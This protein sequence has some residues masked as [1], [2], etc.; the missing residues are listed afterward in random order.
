[1]LDSDT[2]LAPPQQER[3][4]LPSP[5]QSADKPLE[6]RSAEGR[7]ERA[8]RRPRRLGLIGAVVALGAVA[9]AAEGVMARR[10]TDQEVATWTDAQAEPTVEVQ[11]PAL[12]SVD[13]QL[14]LPGNVESF[15]EAPIFSRVPGYLQKW[16]Y[17][18]GS[19]VKAGTVLATID[20]PDLDEQLAQARADLAV[21]RAR[22]ELAELTAR[23]WNA[24]RGSNSVS[25]QS[26]DEKQGEAEAQR[27]QV[28]AQLAAVQRLQALQDFRKLTAPF[29][30][31]VTARNTDVG[32]LINVGSN[33][34]QPL[35]KVADMHE[36]RVY[37]RVP[38]A[39]ASQ[40]QVGMKAT[41]TEPQFP[42]VT[43]PAT[44]DTLSN[45]VAAESRTVLV[46]LLAPN[47]DGKLWSGT[48]AQVAFAL[49]PDRS[50]LRVPTSAMIFRQAGPELAVVGAN[51]KVV[52]KSVTIGRN[53]GTEMEVLSGLSPTDRVIVAPTDTLGNGDAVRLLADQ[54]KDQKQVAG[55]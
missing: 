25:V 46:E 16:Y 14:V 20:T 42:G 19:K 9:A 40:L 17:D 18:I 29:D 39:Y 35:F 21:A 51:D 24:L 49:P 15:Y 50:L 1:M 4:Q 3:P 13:Q 7:P 36:M 28:N 10:A 43:F 32:A 11:A 12:G 53:F 22:A 26:A 44:L 54:P 34:G 55:G 27:A 5:A 31:I 45:A 52:M 2:R 8:R 48:Y 41:L 23:R 33:A 47:P 38:Q 37:V 30:G 6:M